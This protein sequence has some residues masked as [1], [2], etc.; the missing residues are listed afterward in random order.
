[1]TKKQDIKSI[2]L[3]NIRAL[4]GEKRRG[5]IS[6]FSKEVGISKKHARDIL[7][8]GIM[9]KIDTLQKIAGS[10]NLTVDMLLHP[11]TKKP[12][13]DAD[14][15]EM[16]VLQKKCLEIAKKDK[17]FK[18]NYI[19]GQKLHLEMFEKNLEH[20]VTGTLDTLFAMS[21]RIYGKKK[22]RKTE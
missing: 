16:V 2:V 6:A 10:Y 18:R 7:E 3:E 5:R 11:S 14:M 20:E 9:P 12:V 13:I 22:T 19:I 1:M 4:A 15:I 21:S 8:E 17:L